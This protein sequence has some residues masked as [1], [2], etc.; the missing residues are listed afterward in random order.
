MTP[1]SPAAPSFAEIALVSPGLEEAA[2]AEL[3]A[4]GVEAVQ[5]LRRAVAA[6]HLPRCSQPHTLA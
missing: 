3:T 6:S 2:A 1:H 5:P 4:L